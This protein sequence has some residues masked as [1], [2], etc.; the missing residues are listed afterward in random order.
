[1]SND[2]SK[3]DSNFKLPTLEGDFTYYDVYSSPCVVRGIY[4]KPFLRMPLETAIKM[5]SGVQALNHQTSG[6]RVCFRT[7][8]RRVAFR[9]TLPAPA[10]S[11]PH[12]ALVGVR[13][14]DVYIGQKNIYNVA[15]IQPAFNKDVVQGQ[16]TLGKETDVTV[17]LPLYG[18]VKSF[19][20][21]IDHDAEIF[22]PTPFEDEKPIVFYGSSITQGGC[23]S[24]PGNSYCN[25]VGRW[26][27][28]DVYCLG[29]SGCAKGEPV[30]AEYVASLDMSCFVYDYDYNAHDCDE[31]KA[32]HLPFFK[33]VFEKHPDIPYVIMTMP[34]HSNEAYKKER[35]K[36]IYETYSWAKAKGAKVAFLNAHDL[37]SDDA[38]DCCTVDGCHPTDLGFYRMAKAVT[39]A[40]KQLDK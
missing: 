7:N 29:F 35:E 22:A 10:T 33:T 8:S 37:L 25:M 6:G 40:I 1:M 32:T 13:G 12:M 28:S 14:M 5:P 18:E 34:H 11:M 2:I 17:Y 20:I 38:L 16:I 15:T 3:I 4:G 31:L 39:K 23:A 9:M 24:K 30:M 36:I 26:L 21:G 19:E 27:N